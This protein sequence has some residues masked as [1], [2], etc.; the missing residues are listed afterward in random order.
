MDFNRCGTVFG[1][2]RCVCLIE[3][4]LRRS[5]SGLN[6]SEEVRKMSECATP[7]KKF[8]YSKCT[9]TCPGDD[10]SGFQTAQGTHL[11][12]VLQVAKY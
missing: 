3:R 10:E 2:K 12:R 7:Q 4:D 9:D 8:M 1:Y 6:A 5:G 11:V